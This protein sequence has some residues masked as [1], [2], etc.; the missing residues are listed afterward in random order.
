MAKKKSRPQRP[1]AEP[2]RPAISPKW[3]ALLAFLFGTGLY[4]NTL[5]HDFVFDDAPL[6]TQNQQV[7]ELRWGDIL[8]TRGYRP[9]RTLTYAFNYALGG[10][11][12]F[13]Y[14]LF[15]AILH[16]LNALLL[17]WLLFR[18]AASLPAAVIGTLV[19]AAHPIQTAAAAY[20]SGRK[21]LLAT[22]FIL[23][24]LLLYTSFRESGR[25][26]RLIAALV[27]FILGI[28][29]KEVAIVF[30]ALVLVAEAALYVRSLDGSA[31]PSL[32][33]LWQSSLKRYS[34]ILAIAAA[35]AGSGLYY[36]MVIAPASRKVGYWGGSLLTNTATSFKL[37]AHYARLVVWPAPLIADYTGDVFPIPS[38]LLEP[39][40]LLSIAFA[41]L[42]AAAVVYLFPRLPLVSLGLVW[43][44]AALVP[45][46]HIIPFHEIAADHFLYLPMV[47]AALAL[48][49]L[50]QRA[51]LRLNRPLVWT[52]VA[53]LSVVFSWMTLQRNQVWADT[54][55]LWKDTYRKAPDSYR[56]NVN[57]G[58]A[59]FERGMATGDRFLVDRGLAM[60]RHGVDLDPEDPVGNA[61]LG[62]LYYVLAS[63]DSLPNGK[64]DSA[65]RQTRLA[66][67][68]LEKAAAQDFGNAS[69]HSN[70][71]NCRRLLAQILA[72]RGDEEK[73]E[74]LRANAEE[75]YRLALSLD[76]RREV[77][78]VWYNLAGLHIDQKRYRE[79][80]QDLPK[81][82]AAF[83]E[84]ANG[85]HNLAYCQMQ[86]GD[87]RAAAANWQKSISIQPAFESLGYLAQTL[88]QLH[89]YDV[90]IRIYSDLLERFP[91]MARIHYNLGVVYAK[92]GNLEMALH[93]FQQT[94]ALNGDEEAK[95][96][97]RAELLRL[98]PGKATENV[99]R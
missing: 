65:D 71:G 68:Y 81:Y 53:V 6:I 48:G 51:A 3:I 24:G 37:F 1:T 4:L 13:G 32:R 19:F 79:A 38:G 36:A 83:P 58:M 39:A 80:S 26:W 44:V 34:W 91:Q 77:A 41:V 56:A 60:V 76:R 92:S 99:P 57:L 31:R 78:A 63:R 74:R 70:L 46:L 62:S 35:V 54:V 75:S 15:N 96:K 90:A 59:E 55:S 98:Q 88:E 82:I 17:F 40:V 2:S 86:L 87:Y 10:A 27:L 72:K 85:Y 33:V 42:Y 93:H 12:P 73:A 61:N 50:A 21:D 16:G 30:P 18:W 52:A 14:H 47:G 7:T 5:W 97:A 45:I 20:V 43:F 29:S 94:L 49:V 9:V 89:D 84:A 67:D 25:L 69:V 8:S 22:F 23:A 11:D 95:A 28:F 64:A 66:I